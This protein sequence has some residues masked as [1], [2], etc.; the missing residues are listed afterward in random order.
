MMVI[1]GNGFWPAA[2][3]DT[4]LPRSP[5]VALVDTSQPSAGAGQRRGGQRR[6]GSNVRRGVG[7]RTDRQVAEVVDKW[8][9]RQRPCPN[10]RGYGAHARTEC[11]AARESPIR[12][13]RQV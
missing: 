13:V 9:G 1:R 11:P 7:A 10:N 12:P 3:S 6:R 4:N 2:V 5:A 8:Y